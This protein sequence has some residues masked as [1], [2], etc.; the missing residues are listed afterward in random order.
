MLRSRVTDDGFFFTF[1]EKRKP[2]ALYADDGLAVAQKLQNRLI[3][4]PSVVL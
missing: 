3:C 2:A 4:H 1:D